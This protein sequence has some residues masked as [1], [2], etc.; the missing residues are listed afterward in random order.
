ME[1]AET[2]TPTNLVVCERDRCCRTRATP[3]TSSHIPDIDRVTTLHNVGHIPM[4]EAP[5]TVVDLIVAWVEE[6]RPPLRIVPPA[7]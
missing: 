6:H 3:S 1:L 7:G 2:G 4:F 5:Q